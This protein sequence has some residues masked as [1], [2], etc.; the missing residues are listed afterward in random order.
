MADQYPV[1]NFG[2]A[3]T[4]DIAGD[5]YHREFRRLTLPGL[6]VLAPLQAAALV[7]AGLL[8]PRTIPWEMFAYLYKYAVARDE[9]FA[10]DL[11]GGKDALWVN[12]ISWAAVTLLAAPLVQG[13]TARAAAARFLDKTSG[14][15]ASLKWAF[16]NI[17][18]LAGTN[19]LALLL[20]LALTALAALI[21]FLPLGIVRLAGLELGPGM[22]AAM[23]LFGLF[24]ASAIALLYTVFSLRLGIAYQVMAVEGKKYFA[25]VQRSFMLT[26][27]QTRKVLALSA[28]LCLITLFLNAGFAM[29]P[30]VWAYGMLTAVAAAVTTAVTVTVQ[31]VF[32]F[33]C[34]ACHEDLD[35]VLLARAGTRAEK[36]PDND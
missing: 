32:Y 1:D 18:P 34:R 30:N 27:G 2:V 12:L 36:E 26:G 33:G 3:E 14:V 21:L 5:L 19:L 24:G 22:V 31:T 7:A 16:A 8:S 17:I 6:L 28:A 13:A 15:R 4:L 10:A 11:G 9:L 29:L 25:A 23:F 35:I 20:T